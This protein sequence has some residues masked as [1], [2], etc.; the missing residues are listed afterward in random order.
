MA[1]MLS[2]ASPEVCRDPQAVSVLHVLSTQGIT[3]PTT[4]HTPGSRRRERPSVQRA[5]LLQ[6]AGGGGDL[7]C[8]DDEM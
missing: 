5:E 3:E 1:C 6:P 4:L 2:M 8:I 7:A